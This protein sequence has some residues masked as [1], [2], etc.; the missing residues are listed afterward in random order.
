MNE[1]LGLNG[2]WKNGKFLTDTA[3]NL[4]KGRRDAYKK[5]DNFIRRLDKNCTLTQIK[6]E[7]VE[8]E[9]E[10]QKQEYVEVVSNVL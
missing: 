9:Q 6:K 7:I 4:V 8:I 5:Y 1:I 10:E 3:T 2:V